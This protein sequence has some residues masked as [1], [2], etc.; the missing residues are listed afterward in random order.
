[1]NRA[2]RISAVV[3]IAWLVAACATP[4]PTGSPAVTAVPE[5]TSEPGAPSAAPPS[6]APSPSAEPTSSGTT[7]FTGQVEPVPADW[8][9][10]DDPD[11][12]FSVAFPGKPTR[13]AG[14]TSATVVSSTVDQWQSADASM[15][16]AVLA[17]HS[18]VGQFASVDIRSYLQTL[19]RNMSRLGN[20]DITADEES[21]VGVHPVRDSLMT[22]PGGDLCARFLVVGDVTFA[23]VGSARS[24][25]PPHFAAFLGSFRP[26]DAAPPSPSG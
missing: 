14:P 7:G 6:T 24:Q 10:F 9:P 5:A 22:S 16:Y 12:L 23:V 19:E 11:G 21:S 26:T 15:T 4:A 18:P 25:C 8:S 17:S 2:Q 13:A 3:V 20:A 1:M